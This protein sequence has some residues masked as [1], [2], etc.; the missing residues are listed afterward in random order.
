MK[1]LK[2]HAR[3]TK[4]MKIIQ[5]LKIYEAHKTYRISFES[6]ENH[7]N[8]RIQLQNDENHEIYKSPR[9]NTENHENYIIKIEKH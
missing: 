4:I 5:F 1:I 3:I 6:Y 2:F 7:E 9:K 8:H